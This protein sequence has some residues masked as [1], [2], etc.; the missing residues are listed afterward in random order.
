MQQAEERGLPY[1]FKLKKTAKVT[2]HIGE[3]W[4][5]SD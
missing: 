4:G 3:L 1:L 5:R 2:R